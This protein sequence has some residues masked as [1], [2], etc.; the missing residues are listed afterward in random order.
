MAAQLI[1]ENEL[2]NNQNQTADEITDE[3][4]QVEATST[5]SEEPKQEDELPEK[6]RGKS[7]LE[8]AKMHQEAEKLIGRQ[9]NEVHEVRSLADQL[10]KQQLESSKANA[11]P[12]EESLEEDFFVDPKQAVNRQVEKHP[13]VIEARQAALEMKKMKTAQQLS[14]KHPD[15]TTIA[16]DI[17]FQDWVK[18]SKIRLNLFAKADADYDFEAAD[19]LLSTYKE[20]KQVKQQAQNIQTAVVESKAQDKAM[21]AASVDVGGSGETSRK[22]Y[23][24]ADLIK[25]RMT[26]PDR[27]MAL[28]DEIMSAYA[29]GRVK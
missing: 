10:L 21:K 9:A 20:L 23:R 24:R 2:L 26:D 19:E 15:F 4:S 11:A 28:Q 12:I 13:A 8:I 25:L 29:Q 5:V 1:D 3:T 27:Y 22:V 16:Q 7:A 6:Y 18:S 14:T 17:G